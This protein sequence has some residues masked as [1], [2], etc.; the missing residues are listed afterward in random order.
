M[1][2]GQTCKHVLAGTADLARRLRAAAEGVEYEEGLSEE[3]DA[4][5]S[6]LE[7]EGQVVQAEDSKHGEEEDDEDEEID[8]MGTPLPRPWGA[9]VVPL[10]S[11]ALKHAQKGT[12]NRRIDA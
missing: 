6:E 4:E 10:S 11:S 8:I 3:D 9:E 5:I 7:E 1:P 2:C 12:K